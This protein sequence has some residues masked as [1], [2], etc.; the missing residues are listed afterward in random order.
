VGSAAYWERRYAAHGDSGPGSYGQTSEF[1]ARVL[2]EFVA[3]HDVRSVVEFGCGDGHQ[4]GLARYPRY[5]GLDVAPTA[6]RRCAE[7]FA[8]DLSK[9]FMAYE[10][11]AFV[12]RGALTAD[13]VISLDVILHLVEDDVYDTYMR[14]VFEAAERFV[15]VFSPNEERVAGFAPHVRF[16]RFTDWIEVNASDWRLLER[17][18][19]PGKGDDSAADFYFFLRA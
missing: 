17:V 14:S 16:R 7:L 4:L 10:P 12:N 13:L 18:E 19:N 6:V 5:L 11:S 9:S 2:N 8:D 15:A 3:R 1:K